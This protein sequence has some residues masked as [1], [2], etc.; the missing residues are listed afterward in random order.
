MHVTLTVRVK[1]TAFD[2]QAG[3]LHVSGT[4]AEETAHAK[5]GQHHTLDLELH[6]NFTLEKADGWDSVSRG[7]VREACD[8]R[9]GAGA[10]AVIMQEGL[11]NLAVLMGERTVLRQRVTVGIPGKR[12]DGKAHDKVGCGGVFLA[13]HS[14]TTEGHCC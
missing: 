5:L 14:L 12:A 1:S 7:L 4:I 11:A 9:R 10:W 2:V 3:Q 6:R 8:A 13:P